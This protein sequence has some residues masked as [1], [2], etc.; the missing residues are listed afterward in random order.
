LETKEN[1]AEVMDY[2]RQEI[3][4]NNINIQQDKKSLFKS[5]ELMDKESISDAFRHFCGEGCEDFY[6]YLDWLGISKDPNI[7]LLSSTHHYYYD[8]DDL[9]STRNIVHLTH[10]NHIKDL[11]SFMHTVFHLVPEGTVFIGC[12]TDTTGNNNSNPVHHNNTD[13]G[14][15]EHFDPYENGISSRNSFFNF[16]YNLF[17][18]KTDRNMNKKSVTL[19]LED[20]GFKILDMTELNSNTYFCTRKIKH[21][22]E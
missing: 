15:K 7:I 13:P 17:D 22:K 1:R 20:Y 14:S 18:L 5:L 21:S 8:N 4:T 9:K 10:L 3:T 6:T 11:K 12:F 2:G 16:F 19:L